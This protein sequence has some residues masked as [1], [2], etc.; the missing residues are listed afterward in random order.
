MA[1]SIHVRLDDASAAALG[2]LRA[3]GLS[4][5]EAVRLALREAAER[6][7]ARAALAAEARAL[8]SDREDLAE[9]RAV[10]GL[11]AELAPRSVD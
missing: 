8:A 11:M 7:R 3:G 9:A 10:R 4:D 5:S 1:R 6:R 2:L